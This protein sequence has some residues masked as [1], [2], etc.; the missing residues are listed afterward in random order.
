VRTS[1]KEHTRYAYR[2]RNDVRDGNPSHKSGTQKQGQ[3]NEDS[4]MRYDPAVGGYPQRTIYKILYG[5]ILLSGALSVAYLY[6]GLGLS[7]FTILSAMVTFLLLEFVWFDI[8]DPRRLRE[9]K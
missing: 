5:L 4:Q 9:R 1:R 2:S 8:D 3:C 6:D 7:L